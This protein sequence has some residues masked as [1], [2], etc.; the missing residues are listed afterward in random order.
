MSHSSLPLSS[1]CKEIPNARQISDDNVLDFHLRE[2][3]AR[4]ARICVKLLSHSVVHICSASWKMSPL[5]PSGLAEICQ[6]TCQALYGCSSLVSIQ[7]LGMWFWKETLLHIFML[8]LRLCRLVTVAILPQW[9]S[10]QT[11]PPQCI[12]LIGW[13]FLFIPLCHEALKL[14]KWWHIRQR[15]ILGL[16]ESTRNMQWIDTLPQQTV[17][18]QP[19]VT[20]GLYPNSYVQQ[21][22]FSCRKPVYHHQKQQILSLLL[23]GRHQCR[24][25]TWCFLLFSHLKIFM[26][27][28]PFL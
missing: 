22:G 10:W 2:N 25:H 14:W 5:P 15:T 27:F 4:T 12:I 28:L 17:L 8:E 18:S 1:V 11:T 24:V 21:I 19:W 7:I 23:Q 3:L 26:S 9:R 20:E 13:G 6:P 16:Y